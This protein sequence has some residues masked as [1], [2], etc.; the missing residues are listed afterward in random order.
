MLMVVLHHWGGAVFAVP[1]GVVLLYLTSFRTASA[2][3]SIV[4]C[5]DLPENEP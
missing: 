3:N 4:F 2:G 1:A 5:A